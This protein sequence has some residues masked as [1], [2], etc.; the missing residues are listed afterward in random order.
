MI[1]YKPFFILL[2]LDKTYFFEIGSSLAFL[3]FI[4][5]LYF[6]K[7]QFYKR[8][9]IEF[10]SNNSNNSSLRLIEKSVRM[11][12]EVVAD[13][14]KKL[15]LFEKNQG[16]LEKDLCLPKLAKDLK[17]NTSYLSKV[18]NCYKEK[19]FANY[20]NHLRID[21][22]IELLKS[23]PLYRK[24]TIKA[25]AEITGFNSTQQ[26]SDSFNERTKSRPSLFINEISKKAS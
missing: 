20:I 5:I 16:Y 26:F 10:T 2:F 6:K 4:F 7:F 21:H 19:S 13:L 24:Y 18:I 17:T 3:F 1:N 14:L 12:N 11:N 8:N 22:M 15:D 9:Y 23:E 25:L